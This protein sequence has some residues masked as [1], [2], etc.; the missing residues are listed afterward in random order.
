MVLQVWSKERKRELK[1][2]HPFNN[3]KA[4]CLS[5]GGVSCSQS[6]MNTTVK[7]N[8]CKQEGLQCVQETICTYISKI[9]SDI[10]Y[11]SYAS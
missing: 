7:S 1:K 8:P 2:L 3:Q 6:L 10:F 4:R 9:P 11:T 5:S